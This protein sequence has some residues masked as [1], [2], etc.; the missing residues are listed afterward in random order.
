MFRILIGMRNPNNRRNHQGGS[1]VRRGGSPS[2]LGV[3]AGGK[4]FPGGKAN[5][6]PARRETISAQG[7]FAR[8]GDF[9]TAIFRQGDRQV[10]ATYPMLGRDRLS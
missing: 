4:T 6:F 2:P 9:Q 8:L 1:A 5:S 10:T 3:I 7:G